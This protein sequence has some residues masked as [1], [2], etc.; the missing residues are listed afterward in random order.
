MLGINYIKPGE[1]H[2]NYF[3]YQTSD[4]PAGGFWLTIQTGEGEASIFISEK[5]IKE[6][7]LPRISITPLGKK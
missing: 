2:S 6:E 1:S 3:P 5:F 4:G 7:V